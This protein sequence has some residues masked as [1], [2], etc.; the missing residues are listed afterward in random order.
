MARYGVPSAG[1][2]GVPMGVLQAYAK[3][4]WQKPRSGADLWDHGAY[5]SQTL[6]VFLADPARMAAARPDA[7]ATGFAKYAICNTACFHLLDSTPDGWTRPALC[8]PQPAG[9][10]AALPLL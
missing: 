2:Y 7:W 1:A 3:K 8:A 9:S 4:H 5:E 6:A 10:P